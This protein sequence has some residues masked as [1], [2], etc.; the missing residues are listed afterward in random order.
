MTLPVAR[1]VT[2]SVSGYAAGYAL[3]VALP[4]LPAAATMTRSASFAFLS[5]NRTALLS[6]PATLRL[7]ASIFS[8]AIQFMALSNPTAL[9]TSRPV[10]FSSNMLAALSSAPG[11]SPPH[12]GVPTRIPATAVP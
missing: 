3:R 6:P 11:N 7:M 5:A 4:Q 1:A 2:P 10:S 12:S 8:A 9:P